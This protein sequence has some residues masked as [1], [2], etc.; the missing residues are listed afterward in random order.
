MLALRN[1]K[2]E[3]ENGMYSTLLV[4][5][6]VLCNKLKKKKKINWCQLNHKRLEE[7]KLR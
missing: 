5:I 1:R 6:T 2:N 4:F 7:E 3:R